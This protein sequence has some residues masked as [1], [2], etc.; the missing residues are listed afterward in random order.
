MYKL[1]V[2]DFATDKNFSFNQC[3]KQE[4]LVFFLEKLFHKSS[5]KRFLCLHILT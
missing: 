5:R 1:H 3:S 2:Q 4:G